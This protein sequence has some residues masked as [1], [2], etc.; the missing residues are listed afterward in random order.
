MLISRFLGYD[1]YK[2]L[3]QHTPTYYQTEQQYY[4]QV[5][6]AGGDVIQ[7]CYDRKDIISE[8]ADVV[9]ELKNKGL[10]TLRISQILNTSEYKIK[11]LINS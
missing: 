7:D 4:K 6:F 11:Q 5:H 2:G 9:K 1:Y 8:R 10:T 3:K